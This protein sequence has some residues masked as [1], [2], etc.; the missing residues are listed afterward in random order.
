MQKNINSYM[1]N[2]TPI[3]SHGIFTFMNKEKSTS[4]LHRNGLVRADRDLKGD[5]INSSGIYVEQRQLPVYN[6]RLSKTKKTLKQN[7]FELLEQKCP[8]KPTLSHAVRWG[9]T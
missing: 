9:T 1:D 7:G 2:K 4:S 5:T 8:N 6:V 3:A